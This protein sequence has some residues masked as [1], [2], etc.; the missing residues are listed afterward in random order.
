ML[1]EVSD[2]RSFKSRVG[3]VVA[4]SPPIG[5]KANASDAVSA[6]VFRSSVGVRTEVGWTGKSP[7]RTLTAGGSGDLYQGDWSNDAP[8]IAAEQEGTYTAQARAGEGR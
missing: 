4:R 5:A 1:T 2:E 6:F 3:A 7:L 8:G